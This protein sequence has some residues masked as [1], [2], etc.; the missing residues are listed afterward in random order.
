M[1]R[2]RAAAPSRIRNRSS[3]EKNT[4]CSTWDRSPPFLAATPLMVILR[5][6]PRFRRISVSN[7]RSRA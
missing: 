7:S 5:L 1:N 3:G 4:V 6:L 2:R